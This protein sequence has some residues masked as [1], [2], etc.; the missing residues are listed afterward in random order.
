LLKIFFPVTIS[1]ATER[2]KKFRQ[3]FIEL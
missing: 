3:R 2:T 1:L